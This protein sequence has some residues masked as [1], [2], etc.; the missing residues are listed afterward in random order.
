MH[1]ERWCSGTLPQR[2]IAG[3]WGRQSSSVKDRRYHSLLLQGGRAI[4]IGLNGQGESSVPPLPEDVRYVAVAAGAQ[5][6]LLLRSDGVVKAMGLN[7]DGQAQVPSTLTHLSLRLDHAGHCWAFGCNAQ[8]QCDVPRDHD[9]AWRFVT[10][11]QHHTLCLRADGMAFACG[12][13]ADGQC[14]VPAPG[15]AAKGDVPP[16]GERY[17]AVACGDHHSLLLRLDGQVLALGDDGYG[18]C[19]AGQPPAL[20]A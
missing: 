18:Q 16:R 12:A 5:H 6:S 15:M 3:G 9:G 14:D 10:C 11:G 2:R 19:Q 13:N 17:A 8:H 7:L 4:A 20:N 1:L